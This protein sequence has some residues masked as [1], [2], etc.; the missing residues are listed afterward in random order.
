[1]SIFTNIC[2]KTRARKINA[3]RKLLYSIFSRFQSKHTA[4]TTFIQH[5]IRHTFD[6]YSRFTFTNNG[7]KAHENE[8]LNKFRSNEYLQM[9][10]VHMARLIFK[11]SQS[12]FKAKYCLRLLTS[13]ISIWNMFK[14]PRV[15]EKSRSFGNLLYP[16]LTRMRI[17]RT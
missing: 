11:T 17:R 2:A 9:L 13:K 10:R 8:Y 3:K 4:L 6:I 12:V 16:V 5:E 1:M 15:R 7:D 14:S